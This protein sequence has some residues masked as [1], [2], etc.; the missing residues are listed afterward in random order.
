MKLQRDTENDAASSL[1]EDSTIKLPNGG[2]GWVILGAA[3]AVHAIAWGRMPLVQTPK[4]SSGL[5]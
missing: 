3:I 5:Y 1:S 2:Y 4:K